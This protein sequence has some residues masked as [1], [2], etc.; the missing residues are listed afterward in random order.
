MRRGVVKLF[1]IAAVVLIPFHSP[2]QPS[3]GP[4]SHNEVL[5]K[6]AVVMTVT[7]GNIQNGSVYVKGGKIVAV[8]KEVSAPSGAASTPAANTSPR[9][10]LTPTHTSR[11]T[12]M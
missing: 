7:H 4:S 6:N 8:G 5:I 2:A 9:A 10:S 3:A 1:S 11:W 12:T